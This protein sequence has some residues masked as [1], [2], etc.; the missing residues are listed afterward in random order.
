M[1]PKRLTAAQR[2]QLPASDFAVPKTR[3]YPITDAHH[4]EMAID[5]VRAS[6]NKHQKSQVYDAVRK[7]FPSVAAAKGLRIHTKPKK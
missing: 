5:D 1:P 7:S 2:D 4:A 3:S 6:G